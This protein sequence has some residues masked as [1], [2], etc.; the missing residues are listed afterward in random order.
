VNISWARVPK[1]VVKLS[2]G[3]VTAS[4]ADVTLSNSAAAPLFYVLLSSTAD[5]RFDRNLLM[6]PPRASVSV[7][8]LFLLEKVGSDAKLKTARRMSAREFEMSLHV[9]FMNREL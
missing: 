7:R 1:T 4:K 8:F 6:V 5:G 9:D 3:G 2:V